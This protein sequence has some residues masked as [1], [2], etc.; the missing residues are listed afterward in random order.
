MVVAPLVVV[1][2]ARDSDE[3]RVVAAAEVSDMTAKC[4][5][6]GD[7]VVGPPRPRLGRAAAAVRI[8]ASVVTT[9][10][11]RVVPKKS[12]RLEQNPTSCVA[13]VLAC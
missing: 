6:S 7:D 3:D 5:G 2:K 10:L 12:P 8:P 1:G 11:E 4:C 13:A 9:A